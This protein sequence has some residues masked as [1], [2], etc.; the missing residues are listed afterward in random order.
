[1]PTDLKISQFADGGAVQVNDEIAAVRSGVNTKV[2][3]GSAAAAD[4]GDGPDDLST[5]SDFG[6]GAFVNTGTEVGDVVVLEDIAGGTPGLPTIDGSQLTGVITESISGL[7]EPG[8][9][10]T[11]GGSGTIA[12]PYVINSTSDVATSADDVTLD[13]IVGLTA[14]NVQDGIQQVWSVADSALQPGEATKLSGSTTVT[15]S[16]GQ[17]DFNSLPSGI[18]RITIGFFGV[19]LTG[20]ASLLV[21]L[22][23]S[24]GIENTGYEGSSTQIT[25]PSNA[26]T[27]YT[28]GFG[29]RTNGAGVLA[30]GNLILTLIDP[31]T[32]S[33]SCSGALGRSGGVEN[34][35]TGGGKSLSAVLD[36]VRITSTST[37]TFDAGKIRI[38]WEI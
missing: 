21:Q 22:G 20:S 17:V 38:F 15:A 2:K 8:S 23:D 5:N 4:I 11:L 29:V 25:N 16:G 12:D 18:N 7:I 6:T 31:S 34:Y 10:V 13:P 3:V 1:M 24:G 9:N 27:S 35:I 30:Y 33:W 37:D 26:V 14:T 32:N 28:A 19:S 36:R